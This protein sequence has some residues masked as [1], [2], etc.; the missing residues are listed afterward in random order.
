MAEEG[1]IILSDETLDKHLAS[2]K[3]TCPN[4]KSDAIE[5]DIAEWDGESVWIPYTCLSCTYSWSQV[6][7]IAKTFLENSSI[8]RNL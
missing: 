5:S 7:K 8:P 1:E 3:H 2:G 4:C 6:F